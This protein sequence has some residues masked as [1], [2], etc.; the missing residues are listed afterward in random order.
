MSAHVI[1]GADAGR[2]RPPPQPLRI[3]AASG[4]VS[5]TVPAATAM[6]AGEANEPSAAPIK[7]P[8]ASAP[9]RLDSVAPIRSGERRSKPRRS[10]LP[11]IEEDTGDHA[12]CFDS[13]SCLNSLPIA[14]YR[15]WAGH[16]Q[17]PLRLSFE[18][19]W[20]TSFLFKTSSDTPAFNRKAPVDRLDL[21]V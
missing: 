8:C 14:A 18:R 19:L 10:A 17:R 20:R 5:A 6:I 13:A 1:T 4:R 12:S 11:G 21:T 15:R 2:T 9:C 3:Q 16:D 7:R